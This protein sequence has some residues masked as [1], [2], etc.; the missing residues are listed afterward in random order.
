M[1]VHELKSWVGSFRAVIRNA[2]TAELRH[3]DRSFQPGDI[4]VLR[5]WDDAA[6]KYTGASAVARITHIVGRDINAF[7]LLSDGAVMLSFRLLD[8]EAPNDPAP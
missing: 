3:N 6:Q 2:K 8:G 5:E 1:K 4:L 7:G